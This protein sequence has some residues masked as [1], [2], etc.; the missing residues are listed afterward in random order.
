MP[1]T[2]YILNVFDGDTGKEKWLRVNKEYHDKVSAQK[3]KMI[4]KGYLGIQI[5]VTGDN[6]YIEPIPK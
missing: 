4:R 5:I 2:V 1:K 6:I 3:R